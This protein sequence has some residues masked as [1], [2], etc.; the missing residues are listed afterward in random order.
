MHK[1]NIITLK[2]VE[3][4]RETLCRVIKIRGHFAFLFNPA[5]IECFSQSGS[6]KAVQCNVSAFK[7]SHLEL[8]Y[9]V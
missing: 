9:S 6:Q 1:V 5:H 3:R 7:P 4:E 8:L 2:E